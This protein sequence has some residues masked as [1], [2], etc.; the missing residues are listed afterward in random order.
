MQPAFYPGQIAKYTDVMTERTEEYLN[1]WENR[2]SLVLT[3]SLP[4][5]TLD[6]L[7]LVLFDT[8]LREATEVRETAIAVTE[9]FEPDPRIPVHIPDWV[10]TPRNRRYLRAVS[11]LES[12]V[13]ELIESRR[14]RDDGGKT[15]ERRDLLSALV[16]SK[17]SNTEIR[18]QLITFLIAGHETTALALTYTLYL[19][20]NHRDEQARVAEEVS[21]LD[22]LATIGD[23]LPRTD[24]TIR[25]AVRLYPPVSLLMREAIRDDIVGGYE[26]PEGALVLC[27][28]W[29]THRRRKFYDDPES[30]RPA[31]W[32]ADKNRPDYAYFPFGGGQRQCIGRRF[33]LLEARLIMASLVKRFRVRTISPR[34]L[35]LVAAMTLAPATPVEVELRSRMK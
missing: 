1:R 10:P 25:E 9:R 22:G 3:E 26:I 14:T 13:V 33:A 23:D 27:S 15:E 35:D 34:K 29:A 4:E 11:R 20:G 32:T 17:M 18:D 8:D 31:R 21:Q 16:E 24:R 6:I 7:G 12:F 30:F 2:D 5:L 28:Q 19:L